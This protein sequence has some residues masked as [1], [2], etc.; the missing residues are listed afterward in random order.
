M[1]LHNKIQY[2]DSPWAYSLDRLR[3]EELYDINS[4]MQDAIDKELYTYV[5][6]I[7]TLLSD[8]KLSA[9]NTIDSIMADA[10]TNINSMKKCPNCDQ[11]HIE[12]RK[13]VCLQNATANID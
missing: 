6:D 10:A 5:F 4:E 2:T 11:Q 7:L 3:Y 1:A 13:Q 8:E 12:N 9:T